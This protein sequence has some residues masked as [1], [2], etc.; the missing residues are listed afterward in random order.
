LGR[1]EHP[2]WDLIAAG[3]SAILNYMTSARDSQLPRRVLLLSD[4]SPLSLGVEALLQDS[5]ELE[6]VRYQDVDKVL[7]RIRAFPP[8]AVVLGAAVWTDALASEWQ[9]ILSDVPQIRLIA[10]S[11]QD[12][13]VRIYQDGQTQTLPDASDLLNACRAPQGLA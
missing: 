8:D 12:N 5:T 7:E 13:T 1:L 6:V 4:G 3:R 2:T 11:L 9:R 10:L